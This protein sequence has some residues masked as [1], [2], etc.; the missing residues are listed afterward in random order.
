MKKKNL[1]GV[2]LTDVLQEMC[3]RVG[4]DYD[5]IDFSKT[6]WFLDYSWTEKEQDKFIEWFS[7]HLRN[8]GPRRELCKYPSLT[9]TKP[10][11]LKFAEQFVLNFAWKTI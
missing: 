8:M 2:Y 6:D 1:H 10:E 3:R 7:Q 4:A 5:E 9:R 11:R